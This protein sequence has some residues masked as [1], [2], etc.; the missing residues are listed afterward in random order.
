MDTTCGYIVNSGNLFRLEFMIA[1]ACVLVYLMWL[2]SYFLIA[3]S[4]I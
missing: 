3:S 2:E 1:I 4:I